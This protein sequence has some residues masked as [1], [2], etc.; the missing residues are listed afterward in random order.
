MQLHQRHIRHRVHV[1]RERLPARQE[2]GARQA[3]RRRGRL[4]ACCRI[5]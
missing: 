5:G 2:D 1:E 4:E 3:D